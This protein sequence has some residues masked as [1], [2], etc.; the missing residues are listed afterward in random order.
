MNTFRKGQI[1]ENNIEEETINK[2]TSTFFNF[3]FNQ[4]VDQFHVKQCAAKTR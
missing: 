2:Y 4:S 3:V 1:K